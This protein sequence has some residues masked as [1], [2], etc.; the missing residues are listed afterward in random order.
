[1]SSAAGSRDQGAESGCSPDVAAA[2]A[3]AS[4]EH[5]PLPAPPPPRAAR[6]RRRVRR[7]QRLRQLAPPPTDARLMHLGRARRSGGRWKPRPNRRRSRCCRSTSPSA[8]RQPSRRRADPMS[9]REPAPDTPTRSTTMDTTLHPRR[10]RGAHDSALRLGVGPP[11]ARSRLSR[12]TSQTTRSFSPSRERRR[13]ITLPAGSFPS[14]PSGS[15]PSATGAAAQAAA[16]IALLVGFFALVEGRR[17]A[18]TR[19]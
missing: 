10:M 14:P 6:M 15:R 5:A 13:S 12:S 19:R 3:A 7:L 4:S 1:M 2:A 9:T 8:R 11:S 17:Q 18:A 16:T